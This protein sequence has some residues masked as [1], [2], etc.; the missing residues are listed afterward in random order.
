MMY[1]LHRFFHL[2]YLIIAE[3]LILHFI[4][5]DWSVF[6]EAIFAETINFE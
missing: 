4:F 3:K 2:F 6:G 1:I 5:T